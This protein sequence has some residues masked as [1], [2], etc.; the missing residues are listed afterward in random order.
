MS[1]ERRPRMHIGLRFE[2]TREPPAVD[3]QR[4]SD[5]VRCGPRVHGD[6]HCGQYQDTVLGP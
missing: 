1:P 3:Q 6:H 4:E 2:L 5:D